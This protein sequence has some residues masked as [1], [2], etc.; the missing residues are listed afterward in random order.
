MNAENGTVTADRRPDDGLR[1]SAT[2]LAGKRV[3]VTRAPHQAAELAALLRE[4]GATPV[5]YPCLA[6]EPPED[7]RP[8]DVALNRAAAGDFDDLVLTSANTV[9]ILAQRLQ[10]LGISLPALPV[11]AVGPKT[12]AAAEAL[13]GVEVKL[14]AGDHV[15]EALAATIAAA[16]GQRILLPQSA[17]ARPALADLLRATGAEV[18]VVA[19]YQTVLGQGGEAVPAMLANGQIEI[20]TFTSSSTAVNFLKRLENEGGDRRDLAG[21][22]LAAIG[23]VTAGTM[24]E[25]GMPADVV[26]ASY[27]LSGLITALEDYFTN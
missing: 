21:L 5:L 18:T 26:P 4:A 2:G 24:A 13:L 12:A 1:P 15:A 20:L 3:V 8:L 7:L 16:P 22:C 11:A 19:A 23:P 27:T 17:I 14:V 9:H 25:L 10:A 6:I